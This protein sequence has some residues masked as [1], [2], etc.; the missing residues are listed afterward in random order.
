MRLKFPVNLQG[1]KVQ[2]FESKNPIF[3][4]WVEPPQRVGARTEEPTARTAL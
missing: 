2:I 4:W 1:T 3:V